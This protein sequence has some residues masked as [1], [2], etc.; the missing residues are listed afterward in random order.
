MR[1]L[2]VSR[3]TPN[4]PLTVARLGELAER[5]AIRKQEVQMGYTALSRLASQPP[6]GVGL[7][8][9]GVNEL[10][11]MALHALEGSRAQAV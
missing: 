2:S 4:E 7:P 8:W 1:R 6:V 5:Y 10:L 11:D 9:K 3:E